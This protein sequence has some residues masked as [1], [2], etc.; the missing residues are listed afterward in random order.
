MSGDYDDNGIKGKKYIIYFVVV[1]VRDLCT[2]EMMEVDDDEED[3]D[4]VS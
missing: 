1:S 4:R 3:D 2:L